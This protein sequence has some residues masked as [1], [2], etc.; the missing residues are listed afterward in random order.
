MPIYLFYFKGQPLMK[1]AN[2][3]FFSKEFLELKAPMFGN[4]F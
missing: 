2:F 4:L 3:K 1:N